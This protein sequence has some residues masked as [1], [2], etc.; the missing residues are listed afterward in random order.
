MK[1]TTDLVTRYVSDIQ[2]AEMFAVSRATIWRWTKA[3]NL[4]E[5]VKLSPGTTRWRL[6]DIQQLNG[7]A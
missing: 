4:P 7:A 5:P 1:V 2:L 3:G 6:A